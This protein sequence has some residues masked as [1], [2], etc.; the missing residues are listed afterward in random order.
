M[1][2]VSSILYTLLFEDDSS[3][4]L[5]RKNYVNLFKSMNYMY[6]LEKIAEW[7]KANKLSVNVYQKM[8]FWY[9]DC[10]ENTYLEMQ[11]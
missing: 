9:L 7:L 11:V 8:N 10:T 3:F 1:V 6:E 4:F 5:Q 2:N